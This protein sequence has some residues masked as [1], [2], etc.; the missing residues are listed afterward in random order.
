[1]LPDDHD[2]KYDKQ[3]Q[4]SRN[5]PEGLDHSDVI[6]VKTCN[7][8]S[9][10]VEERSPSLQAHHR[11]NGQDSEEAIHGILSKINHQDP[12][13]IA[14]RKGIRVIFITLNYQYLYE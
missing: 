8:Y 1:M 14:Y 2:D 5:L 10:V 7:I 4:E 9:K 13:A 6:A 11:S 3:G 12:L